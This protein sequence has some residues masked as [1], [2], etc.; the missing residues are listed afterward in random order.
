MATISK[1]VGKN[2][3]SYKVQVR[4]KGHA[5]E[6]ASFDRLTDARAWA[7]ETEAAMKA[8]KHF[9]AAKR[10]SFAELADDYE[11]TI[12]AGA[13]A[14][15]SAQAQIGHLTRWREEFAGLVVEEINPQRVAKIRDEL[16]T[17][18]TKRGLRSPATVNRYLAT[19]SS[20]FTHA[21]K[22]LQWVERN[23]VVR[24]SKNKEASGRV[25]YLSDDERVRLLA[26][27]EKSRNPYLYTAVVLA[28]STGARQDE[29]M[30][31]RW[32][33]V[34]FARQ[35][36]LLLDGETKNGSGRVLPLTGE[37]LVLLKDRARECDLKDDR[38]FPVPSTVRAF[39]SV[40][41]AWNSAVERAKITDFRWHD[42]RHTTASYLTM[43]GIGSMEVAKILGHKTLQ[44]TARY[45]HLS[46]ERTVEVGTVLTDR[47]GLSGKAK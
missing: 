27:C 19:L 15:K 7:T 23:P 9:G 12:S 43:A 1:R 45:S 41:T 32:P 47:L 3:T 13:D 36:I 30:S 24:V 29:I 31:L 16:L 46:P 22:E 20:C 14:L 18:N 5:P 44:M 10:R 28:L 42:L 38:I 26:E 39:G 33:Q 34:D 11:A 35:T 2:G 8:G 6:V 4:L 40:R 21:V 37:A 25:R 17:E